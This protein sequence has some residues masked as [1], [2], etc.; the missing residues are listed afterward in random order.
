MSSSDGSAAAPG[1]EF[2]AFA[3]RD[4]RRFL[5]ARFA[6]GLAIQIYDVGVGWFVYDVTRSAWSLGLVGLAIFL[7][8]LLLAL[9]AGEVADR[10]DRRL[11]VG[12]GFSTMAL[13]GVGMFV[14]VLVGTTTALP[15]YCLA[16]LFG[17]AR[18]FTMPSLQ[19][20]LPNIV[21]RE[22]FPQ[23]VATAS[24]VWQSSTIAGPALGGVLYALGPTIDFGFAV[25]AFATGAAAIFS[26]RPRP[27]AKNPNKP[28]LQSLLAGLAFIRSQP[29]ILGAISLDLFAVLLGGATALLP[30]YARDILMTGP[31]G[32]GIL[33]SAP[34]VG[35]AATG[36]FLARRPIRGRAGRTMFVA[37]ALFGVAT[38]GFGLSSWLP[39]SVGFL[40]M[41]GACDMVSV[42]IRHTLV[43]H[44]TPDEMRGRVAAVNSIF[45]GASNELG[46]FE[47]GALAALIGPVGSVVFG[48]IG[49]IVVAAA[50]T[51]LFPDLARRDKLVEHK[52]G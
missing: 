41:L 46:Q 3:D 19:S 24:S 34:A 9:P 2:R 20:L 31:W 48:G 30:I 14:T 42:V 10:V 18:A 51:R 36:L 33:R 35:A 39:L 1:P 49:T 29:Q 28:S 15:V 50:W 37:V 11:V 32:L 16:V 38:V 17:T 21:A 44:G 7:P 12:F 26:I 43:Q 22:H 27:M 25:V 52:E 8:N 47:S 23:A 6:M 4:L 45:I 40:A 5:V 13:A